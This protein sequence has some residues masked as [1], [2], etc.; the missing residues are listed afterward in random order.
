[1]LINLGVSI[2]IFYGYLGLSL[3]C[4]YLNFKVGRLQN[5]AQFRP[6]EIID[7]NET[8][9][10]LTSFTNKRNILVYINI[11]GAVLPIIFALILFANN[12]SITTLPIVLIGILIVAVLIYVLSF[13]DERGVR[14]LWLPPAFIG[15]LFVYLVGR[16]LDE[17]L[18]GVT[19]VLIF[20]I[21]TIATFFGADITNLR[22]ISKF[23]ISS[24]FL[25]GKGTA[26]AVFITGPI[27]MIMLNI[28]N[29]F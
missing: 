26:D 28:F 6:V 19:Y 8:K 7:L 14:V 25:G 24:V 1:M 9:Y 12:L 29:S 5:K 15:V 21:T 22:S 2:W 13:S 16:Q 23:P 18:A 11:G 3:I 17:S 20:V 4:S 27:S 10:V